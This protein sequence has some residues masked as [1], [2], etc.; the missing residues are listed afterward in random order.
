MNRFVLTS[1]EAAE[2]EIARRLHASKAL[3]LRSGTLEDI[4]SL[5]LSH[6]E[7]RRRVLVYVWYPKRR[8]GNHP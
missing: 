4:V 7:K 5:A 1:D 2:P 6:A 8:R 3:Y